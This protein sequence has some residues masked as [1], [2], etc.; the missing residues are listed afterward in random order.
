LT[1]TLDV[2]VAEG[3]DGFIQSFGINARIVVLQI[4]AWPHFSKSADQL[5]INPIMFTGTDIKC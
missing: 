3:F 5:F 2:L 1:G 4:S